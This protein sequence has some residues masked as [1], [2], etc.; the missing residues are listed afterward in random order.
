MRGAPPL[1]RRQEIVD[2]DDIQ[3]TRDVAAE[4]ANAAESKLRC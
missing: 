1:E 2:T 4:H 3:R